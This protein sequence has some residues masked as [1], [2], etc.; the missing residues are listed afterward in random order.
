MLCSPCQIIQFSF[1]LVGSCSGRRTNYSLDVFNCTHAYKIHYVV[2]GVTGVPCLHDKIIY[3]TDGEQQECRSGKLES[4]VYYKT[5]HYKWCTRSFAFHY[6]YYYIKNICCG[7]L[8]AQCWADTIWIYFSCYNEGVYDT[9]FDIITLKGLS[10]DSG[11]TDKATE[12]STIFT[13]DNSGY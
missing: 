5:C 10:S 12:R 4:D 3:G 8:S 9:A 2:F 13:D 1:Y 11:T 7:P 6:S